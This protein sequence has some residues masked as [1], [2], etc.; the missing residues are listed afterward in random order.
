MNIIRLQRYIA[1]FSVFLFI[2][3]MIA[4]YITN[5]VMVLTDAMEGIVNMVTGFLGLYSIILAAKPRDTNHPYGHGKVQFLSSAVE[6]TLIIISGLVIIYES[7][8]QLIIP[9]EL[10]KLDIGLLIVV[11]AGLVNYFIGKYAEIQGKKQNALVLISAGKHLI[12][13]SYSSIA[14][15]VGL[16]LLMV[17]P[18]NWYWL[19]SAV[20]MIF[21]III[22][23][24]GYKILKRSISGIM[25]EVDVNMAKDI[26]A[27]L[28]KNRFAQ[29]IDLHNLRVIQY[30][31]VI[32]LDA[33]M[34]LPLF[35]SVVEAETEVNNLE[36]LIQNHLSH[37]IEVF[38]HID[39]CE[40]YQCKICSLSECS[41]RKDPF[42]QQVTWNIYNIWENTKHGQTAIIVV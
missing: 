23:I 21:A 38:I 30:G 28:Q 8:E 6:G 40:A 20:A 2:G 32:H 33:H 36:K 35:Y 16:L 7:I 27:L 26:I 15:I 29:W 22:L 12:T 5:S 37:P 10:K 19:D 25:D 13:D 14:I 24:T 11:G 4:W 1:F 31:D 3:K 34:T 42:A 41:Y 18:H 17:V 39:A 9:H